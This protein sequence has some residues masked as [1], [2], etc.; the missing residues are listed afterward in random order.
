MKNIIPSLTLILLISSCL[1]Q[2]PRLVLPIGHTAYLLSS[3]FSPDGKRVITIDNDNKI[4]MWDAEHGVKLCELKNEKGA[5]C[6]IVIYNKQGTHI[7][8][9]NLISYNKIVL[10]VWDAKTGEPAFYIEHE[11]DIVSIEFS[12]DGNKVLSVSQN[13]VTKLWNVADGSL[14]KTWHHSSGFLTNGH[15]SPDGHQVIVTSI[16]NT[17]IYNILGQ[18]SIFFENLVNGEYYSAGT[19]YSAGIHP[20]GKHAFTLSDEFKWSPKQ[21]LCIW[22]LETKSK[23]ITKTL[24]VGYPNAYFS[25]TGN[26]IILKN[27]LS[28]E[29]FKIYKFDVTTGKMTEPFNNH[30]KIKEVFFNETDEKAVII[31]QNNVVQVWDLVTEK[32]VFA[33]KS[34]A[35]H[36]PKITIST[37]SKKIAIICDLYEYGKIY[38]ANTGTLLY[39]LN[40]VKQNE[41]SAPSVTDIKFNSTGDKLVTACLDNRAILWRA[42][43]G[44]F[45]VELSGNSQSVWSFMN[46]TNSFSFDRRGA[47][48][49]ERDLWNLNTGKL[50]STDIYRDKNIK[51]VEIDNSLSKL[52]IVTKD[53]SA[54]E[55]WDIG[56]KSIRTIL[57]DISL[58]YGCLIKFSSDGKRLITY[59]TGDVIK[60]WNTENGKLIHELK[61]HI[62]S[63][64]DIV[65]SSDNR[66][67]VSLDRSNSIIIW[68]L[69][70]GEILSKIDK[71]SSEDVDMFQLTNR[72]IYILLSI[73]KTV[74]I[75]ELF[76]GK[77]KS[78]FS[79]DKGNLR[80]FEWSA[81]YKRILC[82]F[83]YDKTV[84]LWDTE[85][86]QLVHKF[87][88]EEK[89]DAEFFIGNEWK[90]LLLRGSLAK[91]LEIYNVANGDK[92]G[93]IGSINTWTRKLSLINKGNSAIVYHA[94]G[95][96]KSWDLNKASLNYNIE[97][98]HLKSGLDGIFSEESIELIILTTF[99]GNVNIFD[100]KTGKFIQE[101]KSHTTKVNDARFLD[102]GKTLITASED[103][104]MK[105]WN[106]AD[107][108]LLNTFF[109]LNNGTEYFNQIPSGYYQCTNDAAKLLHYV[110]NNL[111]V[112][113]FEQLDVKYNRPDKVLEVIG[114]K[115]TALINS[116][117]KAYFKR[118]KKLGIDTAS[119]RGGYSVPESDFENRDAIE[120]EQK[121]ENLTLHIKGIDSTYKLD[122][123]NI[124]INEIP[125]FGQKGFNIKKRNRNTLD[126]TITIQL[127]QGENRIETS[128]LNVNGTE[129]YRMPLL[130]NYTPEKIEIEKLYFIGIGIDK[131][132]DS[133]YNLNYSTK[134]IGDL[135][136]KLREKFK[137][138]IV[139]DT[140]FNENVTVAK[141]KALKKKLL[142]SS[143]NDKVIVSYSG[144]GLLSKDYDYYLSTYSVNF[145]KPEINGLP[146]DELENLL[147]S[148]P[149]RKKLMLIDACHSGEVDKDEQL[150]MDNMADSMKLS[151]PKGGLP[152]NKNV[153]HQLGL[154]N[155]FELMQSLF[156]NVGKSTGATI[157]S[158]AAGNQYAL[159]RGDLKNGVFTYCI[160][161]ALNSNSTITVSQLKLTVGKR[162]VELTNGLQKPTSRNETINSD[163]RVW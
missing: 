42:S 4:I 138:D 151:K 14:L 44:K 120:Y 10:P 154:K 102:Y 81:D 147:D 15:F 101:L 50:I 160:L 62:Y 132:A 83:Y 13:G 6:D 133:T 128:I 9:K 155:S 124:W 12:L 121:N 30:G 125:L 90:Y 55:I 87:Q 96:V 130:V 161:E 18:D 24:K 53:P 85:N 94:D 20:D 36:T 119:F 27:G 39:E 131:F 110:T 145:E 43:D 64:Y 153:K 143:V 72:S 107:G 71:I 16:R 115:D 7:L 68:D 146:Y 75:Y 78:K 17:T 150:A 25:H 137:E 47:N 77:L 46:L 22:N 74:F 103:H 126:T 34:L 152:V 135:S 106:I 139:I 59:G 157:I 162:V 93:E 86:N 69:D 63:C 58:K 134:D 112:I 79:S 88:V 149:A 158:A 41:G 111:K 76:T 73:D 105:I 49:Y 38:D 122:R 144:H 48:Y 163:W 104:T 82:S 29:E 140:L 52:A 37:D 129:S 70:K 61:G 65:V 113:S 40:L 32:K 54:V 141:V 108:R 127:S 19:H 109:S 57:Q 26:Y 123:F 98:S 80:H 156:V 5:P 60:I 1:A 142:Q 35:I 66:F 136:K 148:I 84:L 159:E 11:K 114:C 67:L 33:I 89:D 8:G 23:V 99:N 28:L 91:H 100:K 31:N 116:Y 118:I 97:K 56:T 45:L 117:R 21:L 92:I 95:T 51:M 2:T 3:K